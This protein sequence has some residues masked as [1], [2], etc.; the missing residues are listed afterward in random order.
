M[1]ISD[2]YAEAEHDRRLAGSLRAGT[3]CDIDH[4]SARA[5]VRIGEWISDWIPWSSGFAGEM[6]RW[7]PPSIGEQVVLASPSGLPEGGFI[8]PGYYTT[9][10]P[11][12]DE[13]KTATV[14]L[15]PD[16]ARVEYDWA[17]KKYL[18]DI[19]ETGK[20]V[21][22]IGRTTLELRDDGVLL[23]TPKFEGEEWTP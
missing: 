23:K 11:A 15:W 10:H 20:I 2:P 13:R 6:R 21:L 12:P 19:P 16:G 22:K 17:T 9:E 4:R 1:R 5:R 14:D 7:R 18:I 8:L 3:I